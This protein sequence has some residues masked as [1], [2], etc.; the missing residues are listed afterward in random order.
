MK[1]LL[2]AVWLL[3]SVC[4]PGSA[5]LSDADI[6][7]AGGF[8]YDLNAGASGY[9]WSFSFAQLTDSHIGYGTKDYASPGYDDTLAGATEGSAEKNLRAAVSWINAHK[10]ELKIKFVAVTGDITHH[11]QKSEFLKAREILDGL[12]IP[13]VPIIG[14]HDVW[15]YSEGGEVAPAPVGDEYFKEV[16]GAEFSRLSAALPDWS[17][18]TRLARVT[19]AASGNAA[20]FQNFSFRYGGYT[21]AVVDYIGRGRKPRDKN[22]PP[23]YATSSGAAGWLK[24]FCATVAP[25]SRRLVVLSHFPIPK[26]P[27]SGKHPI[28]SPADHAALTGMLA[29]RPNIALWN[30]GHLHRNNEHDIIGPD[31]KKL[32]P[33]VETDTSRDTPAFRVIRVWDK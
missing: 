22:K 26:E 10:A 9:A 27:A 4:A 5:A 16:F 28:F 3:L 29:A 21:F 25:E 17:D 2:L 12:D 18:G 33:V 14:N 23:F 8:T 13:Y 11:G 1:K 30:A 19:D 24:P 7:A 31:G 20:F 32:A 15:P 6:A